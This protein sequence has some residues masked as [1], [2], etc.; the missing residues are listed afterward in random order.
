MAGPS[1]RGGTHPQ[2]TRFPEGSQQSGG[3][4]GTHSGTSR[5]GDALGQVK[6]GAQHLASEAA[7]QAGR[8]W[9]A[10]RETV[11]QG[12]SAVADRAQDFW[13]GT[14]DL[15]RRY[16][17]ASVAIAFGAGCLF[18]GLFAAGSSFSWGESMPERMSRY[19]A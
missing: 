13:S 8:A 6:E 4:T 19:S 5:V 16:P 17:I 14:Q 15:I 12:A 11:Q 2:G 3:S 18:A 1:D 7:H 10:T 9:E